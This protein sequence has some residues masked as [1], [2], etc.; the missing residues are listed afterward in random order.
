MSASVP[1]AVVMRA[2]QRRWALPRSP[3]PAEGVEALRVKAQSTTPV[4]YSCPG[5]DRGALTDYCSPDP[6]QGGKEPKLEGGGGGGGCASSVETSRTIFQE[7]EFMKT[8]MS[9]R[10]TTQRLAGVWRREL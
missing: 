5:G 7:Y 4:V 2:I 1:A 3:P 9:V 6:F 10:G 8:G